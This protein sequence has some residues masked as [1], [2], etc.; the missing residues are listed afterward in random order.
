[1]GNGEILTA[2]AIV[3]AI[4]LMVAFTWLVV[5]L[6][7]MVRKTRKT[8]DTMQ[9]QLEPTLANVQEITEQ[10]KPLIEKVDPLLTKA[11]PLMDRVTLTVDAANLEIMR[12]D[13]I[14]EDVGE[15]ADTATSA[16]N[17]MDT[18]A[19]TPL[20]MLTS[21]SSKLRD[22][23]KPKAASDESVALGEAKSSATAAEP[24]VRPEGEK[25]AADAKPASNAAERGGYVTISQ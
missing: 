13:K 6:V 12:L 18:V 8:V 19:S 22:A 2:V 20:H 17:A 5:E 10:V 16:V 23:F 9:K 14:L 21:A 4:V 11:D 7:M 25:D 15:I 1:M 3:A 24:A